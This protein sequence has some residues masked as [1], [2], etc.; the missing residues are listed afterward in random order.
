MNVVIFSVIFPDIEKYLDDYFKSLCAQSYKNF[1]ILI[2]NDGVDNIK[3]YVARYPQLNISLHESAGSPVRNREKG[4]SILSEMSEA[5]VLF[6]DADDFFQN[7]RI[8]EVVRLIKQHNCDIVVN[9]LSIVDSNGN[10]LQNS[11][12][13]TRLCNLS[14]IELKDIRHFNFIGLSNSATYTKCLK[15][16]KLSESLIAVDW[17]MFTILLLRGY[18]AI[19]T[20]NTNTFYRQHETNLVGIG[21]ISLSKLEKSIIVK[22]SHYRELSYQCNNFLKLS[23]YYYTL[24]QRKD[25]DLFISKY[26]DECIKNLPDRPFWWEEAMYKRELL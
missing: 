7:N 8:A 2:I 13:S 1:E 18:K 21:S 4:I 16:I 12:F 15:D 6:S 23:K 3:E 24:K 9:D 5:I 11:Y 19:F 26:Y 20:S 25:D 17:F 14:Y 22:D 10:L